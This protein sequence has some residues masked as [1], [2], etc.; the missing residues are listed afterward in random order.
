MSALRSPLALAGASLVA[1]LVVVAAF[2][3]LIAPYDP[4]ASSGM[5]YAPPSLDHP[6]GTNN[7]GQDMLSRLIWGARASVSVALGAAGLAL[8]IGVFVGVCAA[9]VGGLVD[10]LAMRVVDVLLALPRLPLLVLVAALAGTG[11]LTVTV[12]I[13]LLFWPP[14]ARIVRSRALSLRQRGFVESA[15]GFGAGLPYLIRRHLLP[16]LG[17]VVVA[18]FI[19]VASN[20]V[21]LE[22]SLA[23]LGLADPTG[24]SWGLDINRAL[25]EPGIYFTSAWL[26]WV[27]PTGFAI[28]LAIL[29][30]TLLGVGLEPVLNPR[31]ERGS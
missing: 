30:F 22:A 6:V 24:V 31:W 2:A 15:R 16:A 11:R 26:W 29:G 8:T 28:T 25:A 10:T 9:L 21:L 3:P 19:S 4:G 12:L 27:L 1:L 20:A 17:P 13:G 5:S 18:L 7:L 23:F 14:M